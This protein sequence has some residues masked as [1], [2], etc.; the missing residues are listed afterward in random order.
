[1]RDQYKIEYKRI[2]PLVSDDSES[3]RFEEFYFSA[4]K[5]NKEIGHLITTKVIDSI[6]DL[7]FDLDYPIA[8]FGSI[9]KNY[10]RMGV[11]ENL[12]YNANKFCLKKYNKQLISG[13][14]DSNAMQSLWK[15]LENKG[16]A[17]KEYY[18]EKEYWQMKTIDSVI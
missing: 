9:N 11:M 17:K 5:G 14:E 3:K 13:F 12:L 4:K 1:M 6:D 7:E 2:E 18:N 16:K 15:K 10:R 8:S